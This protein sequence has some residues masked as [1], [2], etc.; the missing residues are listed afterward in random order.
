MP[1]AAQA[2]IAEIGNTVPGLAAHRMGVPVE[3]LGDSKG[4]LGYLSDI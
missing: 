4:E 2:I 3:T 1:P